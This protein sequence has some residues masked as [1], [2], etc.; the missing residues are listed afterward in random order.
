MQLSL[1]DSVVS[2][3]WPVQKYLHSIWHKVG[4]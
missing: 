1:F 3:G 2:T 4:W